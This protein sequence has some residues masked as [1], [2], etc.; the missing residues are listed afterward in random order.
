MT[1]DTSVSTPS[2]SGSN[3]AVHVPCSVWSNTHNAA[4]T[5]AQFWSECWSAYN[6]ALYGYLPGHATPSYYVWNNLAIDGDT[7]ENDIKVNNSNWMNYSDF[8]QCEH[9]MR[10]DNEPYQFPNETADT[11]HQGFLNNLKMCLDFQNA[12]IGVNVSVRLIDP[13]SP[14]GGWTATQY[15]TW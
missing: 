12:G 1:I 3:Q 5:E 8:I 7:F 9:W 2:V 14:G 13:T 4:M 11:T 15:A 10:G 6:S